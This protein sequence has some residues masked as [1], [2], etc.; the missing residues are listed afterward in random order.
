MG[1][2]QADR[3]VAESKLKKNPNKLGFCKGSLSDLPCGNTRF[4]MPK[5]QRKSRHMN[6]SPARAIPLAAGVLALFLLCR[7]QIFS[8]PRVENPTPLTPAFFEDALNSN[9]MDARD[10]QNRPISAR[11]Q[12]PRLKD[13]FASTVVQLLAVRDLPVVSHDRSILKDIAKPVRQFLTKARRWAVRA[14]EL[15]VLFN[16][17]RLIEKPVFGLLLL[18]LACSPPCFVLG[19]FLASKITPQFPPQALPLRC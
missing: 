18:L 6:P 16:L 15:A 5:K 14:F 11:R 4:F 9:D 3:Q 12:A 19:R 2:P 10:A 17:K 8:A 7:P 13:I 1:P